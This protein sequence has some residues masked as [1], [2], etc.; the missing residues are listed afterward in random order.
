MAILDRHAACGTPEALLAEGDKRLHVALLF[1][2]RKD[3]SAIGTTKQD[4][5]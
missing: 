4:G 1:G 5:R 2:A 3:D